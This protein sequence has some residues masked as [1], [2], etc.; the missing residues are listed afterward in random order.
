MPR[1]VGG[2]GPLEPDL[3]AIGEAPGKAED[4]TGIPFHPDAPAGSLL[5]K[6]F[7]KAGV[8]RSS[9]YITNV[10]KYRPPQNNFKLLH[11]VGIDLEECINDL[12]EKEIYP[13][14]PKCILAIGDE[15]L[16]AVTG[17]TG[18]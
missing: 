14:K 6:C 4:E 2:I 9:V 18:I 17:L 8:K 7:E 1:F 13:F 12:W 10:V 11:V 5:T 16:Q 15:A 3:M